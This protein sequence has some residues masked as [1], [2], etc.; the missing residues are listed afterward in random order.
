LEKLIRLK[1]GR[2]SESIDETEEIDDLEGGGIARHGR[3]RINVAGFYEPIGCISEGDRH[4]YK[5]QPES[6]SRVSKKI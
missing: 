4:N 5:F 3:V 6:Q 1:E 2:E